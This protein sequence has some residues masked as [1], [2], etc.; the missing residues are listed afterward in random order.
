MIFLLSALNLQAQTGLT[1]NKRYVECEDQWVAFKMGKDSTHS[2]GFIYI[3]E[4]AGLTFN[5]EGTF[6]FG[7]D[8]TMI[9]MKNSAA[10]VKIRL[11]ANN[12]K[13]AIIPASMF[14][15]LQI[16]TV[17]EW[18]KFYQTNLNTIGRLYKWGFIYNG[19]NECKKALEF[20]IK[21]QS[22]DANYEGLAVELAYSYN[23]L[24]DYDKALE[25]LEDAILDHPTDAYIN[26]EYI[27]SLVHQRNID[28]AIEQ[29]NKSIELV[30][31]TY[32]AENCY[33]SLR[34]YYEQKD[35]KNFIFWKKE[36]KKWPNNNEQV[37]K[38][39]KIMENDLK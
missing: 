36:L 13:V 28:K 20:L 16:D 34:Y 32:N 9:V 5:L 31:Q 21:A 27:Y 22:I 19:W 18:L 38:S 35:K 4:S 37:T 7:A 14:K 6:K 24:G 39:V 12:V 23:C 15:D 8:S 2:Y 11:E 17:P 26:K 25:V 33:N 29:Y 1:Y 30:E 10:N 3:D